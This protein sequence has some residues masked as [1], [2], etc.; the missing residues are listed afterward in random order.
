MN[1]LIEP[2]NGSL[3]IGA[4]IVNALS[5]DVEEYYHATIF[6]E[7]VNGVTTG[8]ES[9]VET[10]TERVLALLASRRVKATF[11][12]LGE[13]GAAHPA[14]VRKIAQGGHEVAC[15]GYHH[16]LVFG[17]SPET[18]RTEIRRAKAVL[19]DVGGR[20]VVG[21]RAPSFSI[22]PGERWAYALLAEE[23]FRYDSSVYPILHDRYGDLEAPRFPYEI[24]RSGPDTLMEFPIGTVRLFGVNLPI[25]GGGYFRLLPGG[26]F[27]AGI[28]RVNTVERKPVMF[29]FHPW[30]LDPGQ[31]RPVMAW[32]RRF[33]HYVGQGQHEA[34]LARLLQSTSFGTALQVLERTTPGRA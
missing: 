11:F 33:R 30:E 21:Y 23:G 6:Q 22:G 12:V 3:P 15:H 29:Y 9:R 32:H 16:D 10:S 19:E 1:A 18:F 2:V 24:W 14:V 27:Q 5:V 17:Q 26:L 20:P 13:V 25:G 34:K 8:L 31:P 28:R 7:A 4:P